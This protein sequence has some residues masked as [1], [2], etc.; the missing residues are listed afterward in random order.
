MSAELSLVVN[1]EPRRISAGSSIADL[2]LHLTTH[3]DDST[4]KGRMAGTPQYMAPEVFLDGEVDARSDLYQLGCVLFFLLTGHVPFEQTWVPVQ[5]RP[6]TPQFIAS[7]ATQAP[8][9]SMKPVGQAQVP[10]LQ[11]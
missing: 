9:H 8:L 10:L 6:Q 11:V 3:G 7:D 4:G 1:G 2:V 5:A